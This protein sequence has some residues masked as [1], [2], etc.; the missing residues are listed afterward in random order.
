L[1]TG[2][3]HDLAYAAVFLGLACSIR[4]QA[5]FMA[6]AGLLFVAG[7][8]AMRW[9][10]WSRFEGAT[11]TYSIPIAYTILLWIGG[12]WLIMGQPFY[13][14]SGTLD[15]LA[16][17]RM[18]LGELLR[19][20]CPWALT[21]L[22]AGIVLAVP[23]AAAI[24]PRHC[25]GTARQVLAAAGL[26]AT[27]LLSLYIRP[28]SL[29]QGPDNERER[30]QH[31]INRLETRYTNTVFI[32][33]GYSGYTFR[34]IVGR[35]PEHR[36]I[37]IMRVQEDPGRSVDAILANYPGRDVALLVDSSGGQNPWIDDRSNWLSP[38]RPIPDRFIY[39]D[40]VGRWAVFEVVR[41]DET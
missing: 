11:L 30:A 3:L 38:Y 26:V 12:N 19:W 39:R 17:T 16:S 41:T 33:T 36:W 29:P 7:G 27:L 28:F 35:D 40:R 1:R 10:G 8:C 20:D 34:D 9:R 37:H 23:L 32:V 24:V 15:R 22:F 18:T 13:F 21:G 14:M 2:S 25:S 31:V 5:I 4:Y 6:A